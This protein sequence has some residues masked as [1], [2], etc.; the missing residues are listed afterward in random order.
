MPTNNQCGQPRYGAMKCP[1]S[2]DPGLLELPWG[3][4]PALL[5]T[6]AMTDPESCRLI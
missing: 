1:G 4:C 6:A 3:N 5:L 2:V